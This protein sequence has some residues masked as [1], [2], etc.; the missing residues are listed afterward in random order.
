MEIWQQF[1]PNLATNLQDLAIYLA[2]LTR[3]FNVQYGYG[4]ISHKGC[5]WK[6]QFNIQRKLK[7]TTTP[8][9]TFFPLKVVSLQT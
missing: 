1:C 9:L 2:I 8:T 7:C 3:T 5:N 4:D 6:G